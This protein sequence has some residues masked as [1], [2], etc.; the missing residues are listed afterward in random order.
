MIANTNSI[1]PQSANQL[2]NSAKVYVS[3][4]LHPEIALEE[5][6][7]MLD[8]NNFSEILD[9]VLEASGLKRSVPATVP[10]GSMGE[11]QPAAK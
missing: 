4:K 9:R 3:G 6:E 8:L 7:G 11:F 1:E 10:A 2:P 5:L